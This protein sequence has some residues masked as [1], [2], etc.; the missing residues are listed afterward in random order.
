MVPLHYLQK[1]IELKKSKICKGKSTFHKPEGRPLK[2]QG[3]NIIVLAPYSHMVSLLTTGFSKRSVEMQV[4]S[5]P[6]WT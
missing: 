1:L 4:P 2:F 5:G 6:P 3:S